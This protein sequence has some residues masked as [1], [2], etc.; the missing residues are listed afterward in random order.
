MKACNAQCG[1]WFCYPVCFLC[2]YQYVVCSI[3]ITSRQILTVKH[4]GPVVQWSIEN[5][6][7]WIS[8]WGA[9]RRWWGS[10][11]SILVTMSWKTYIN[12]RLLQP[13]PG[14]HIP[15]FH[16]W[17][18]HLIQTQDIY[19]SIYQSQ[20]AGWHSQPS[21]YFPWPKHGDLF[22]LKTSVNFG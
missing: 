11:W 8:T 12:I 4:R 16:T 14:H 10:T 5:V 21:L 7:L 20:S 9:V 6:L 17:P 13:V 3:F 2:I 1:K 22:K 15:N 19:F 18:L